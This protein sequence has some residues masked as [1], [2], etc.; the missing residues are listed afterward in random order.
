MASRG[1]VPLPYGQ[2]RSIAPKAGSCGG[3]ST[4]FQHNLPP[5]L[6]NSESP[7]RLEAQAEGVGG[8]HR[9][10]DD[11]TGGGRRPA[12]H[13]ARRPRFHDSHRPQGTRRRPWTAEPAAAFCQTASC[14]RR[15][16][17]NDQALPCQCRW[18]AGWRH[19]QI[20]HGDRHGVPGSVAEI[21]CDQCVL[22]G[23][24]AGDGAGDIKGL[25]APL[26]IVREVCQEPKIRIV[27][28]DFGVEEDR[29]AVGRSLYF[30]RNCFLGL[31]VKR[32][33]L[34]K[35][36][37]A[38]CIPI[39]LDWREFGAPSFI[40]IGHDCRSDTATFGNPF[41]G[42]VIFVKRWAHV[43][44]HSF[45]YPGVDL[46][47]PHPCRTRELGGWLVAM[48]TNKAAVEN[49]AGTCDAGFI[50][51]RLILEIPRPD[52]NRKFRGETDA[53]VVPEV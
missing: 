11:A 34:A 49:G 40:V 29:G 14:Q 24:Q 43:G 10:A 21:G 48:R 53:P 26:D 6:G 1:L 12:G 32:K 15:K 36:V 38:A 28:G 5:V 17:G 3:K 46:G 16:T 19:S 9:A 52:P 51:H 20:F 50:F 22:A 13:G 39:A 45:S 44:K 33:F 18:L 35:D 8:S 47:C 4:N 31:Q 37:L 25:A 27:S 2:P 41:F 42:G 30:Q 7:L 23:R